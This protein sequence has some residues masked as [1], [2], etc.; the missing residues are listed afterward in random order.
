MKC[1]DCMN[2][3][4][5]FTDR[6]LSDDEVVE[7]QQHLDDCPPCKDRFL[8]EGDLKR[9]IKVSCHQD[10]QRAPE[11]LRAKLRQILF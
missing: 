2:K 9:L 1:S 6:E 7:V 3:L 4:D 10:L 5:L 8:F 11:S